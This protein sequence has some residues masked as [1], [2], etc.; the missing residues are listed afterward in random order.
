MDCFDVFSF[1]MDKFKD[2]LAEYSDCG[3][4]DVESRPQIPYF[5]SYLGDIGVAT[6][7]VEKEYINRDYLDDYAAYYV[8]CFN[9]YGRVCARLHLFKS[10]F[11]EAEY[12]LYLKGADNALAAKLRNEDYLGC[13]VVRP[14]PRCIFG[15]SCIRHYDTAGSRFFPT[16]HEC[17]VS[18][19]GKDLQVVSVPYQEQDQVAAACATSALWSA[20][21]VTCQL[22]GHRLLSPVEIT[23]AATVQMP[24]RSRAFPN[25][26]GL[27][28]EA[29]AHAIRAVGLE[30]LYIDPED[31]LTFKL[32]VSAYLSGG[33]P[34]VLGFVLVDRKEDSSGH[35]SLRFGGRHAVAVMGFNLPD[36]QPPAGYPLSMQLKEGLVDKLYVHDDQVGPFA[37]MEFGAGPTGQELD[38]LKK[39]LKFS[40]E[41]YLTTDF[42]PAPGYDE[43]RAYPRFL[44]L[45]LY[46][47]IRILVTRVVRTLAKFDRGLYGIHS[48]VPVIASSR[49]VWNVRLCMLKEFKR[50]IAERPSLNA[51]VRMGLLTRNLP[52]FLWWA[53]A[54]GPTGRLIDIAFDATGIATGQLVCAVLVSDEA[55]GVALEQ[56][57]TDPAHQATPPGEALN[58]V[59]SQVESVL[60]A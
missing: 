30:P 20:F 4:R 36:S 19:F 54:E 14:L 35:V 38:D 33:I 3:R 27:T 55:L 22:F 6:I 56:V 18:L 12:E 16:A 60:I 5:E 39:L 24:L 8:K 11:T 47:K 37:R 43:A 50:S 13:I 46:H 51:E 59:L 41:Y 21:H 29:M 52:K 28:I 1:N 26:D 23:H 25:T 7:V 44:L 57:R 10:S 15:R 17:Q 2:L 49:P 48:N 40:P 53:S 9:D 31:E 34:G 42:P 58:R 45:P 32:V